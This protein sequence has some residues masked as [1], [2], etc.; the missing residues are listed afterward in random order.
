MPLKLPFV[1]QP[2]APE[3]VLVGDES[4]G[5][6][7]LPKLLDLT[8]NERLYIREELKESPD[9]RLEAVRLAKAIALKSGK[10]VIDAYS[11]I[12]SGDTEALGE[13]LEEFVQFQDKMDRV[14]EQRSLVTATA[15]LRFRLCPEWTL[16]DS[17]DAEQ[18]TPK[19]LQAVYDFA[20][21]EEAGW[22]EPP[23]EE[24]LN[25]ESLGKSLSE[26]TTPEEMIPIGEAFI[27]LAEGTP[28]MTTDSQPN[29][30]VSN[31]VG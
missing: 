28:E 10:K 7:Q 2:K 8:P 5:T 27:G 22:K 18:I 21:K 9:L 20:Q 1:S 16:A 4:M 12:T 6:L 11:A 29:A 30:L 23:I 14:T 25:D 24:P 3:L 31:P 26:E 19:L 15:I 17:R 13:H